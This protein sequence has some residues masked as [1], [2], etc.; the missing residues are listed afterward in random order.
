MASSLSRPRETVPPV[1]IVRFGSSE[2]GGSH[3][4]AL[5]LGLGSID[6]FMR[7][8]HCRACASGNRPPFITAITVRIT[9][10]QTG[11]EP[12]PGLGRRSPTTT[13][14]ATMIHPSLVAMKPCRSSSEESR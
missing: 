12:T 14:P 9:P 1:G 8:S 13:L 5:F 4:D 7:D 2:E 11:W 3:R 10:L 6:H